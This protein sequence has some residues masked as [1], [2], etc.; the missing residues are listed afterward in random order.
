VRVEATD[1]PSHL[2]ISC[3]GIVIPVHACVTLIVVSIDLFL[4]PERANEPAV[5]VEATECARLRMRSVEG[6]SSTPSW[7]RSA[8]AAV[9]TLS[10]PLALLA[11]WLAR[12]PM[13]ETLTTLTRDGKVRG[14]INKL[15]S[16][17]LFER[18]TSVDTVNVVRVSFIGSSESQDGVE[19]LPSTERIR[20]R[21]HSV[22]STRTAGSLGHVQV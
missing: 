13:K 8:F 12:L 20:S 16:S 21:A 7:D 2:T 15:L 10:L 1:I 4:F 22:A 6:S 17:R 3:P 5:R 18:V 19:E 9:R 14:D 11:R